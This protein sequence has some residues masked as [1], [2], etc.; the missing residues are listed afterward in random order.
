MQKSGDNA[1]RDGWLIL[2][3]HSD[4]KRYAQD[5]RLGDPVLDSGVGGQG[6]AGSSLDI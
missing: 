4:P 6:A 1:L 2:S 3:P 5:N